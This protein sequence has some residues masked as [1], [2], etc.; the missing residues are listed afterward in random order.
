[1]KVGPRSVVLGVGA[2]Y[3]AWNGLVVY[4]LSRGFCIFSVLVLM[5]YFQQEKMLYI[6]QPDKK[7]PKASEFNPKM[8]RSPDEW[9]LPYESVKIPTSD[10]VLVHGWWIPQAGEEA[11]T[12]WTMLYFHGNAGN[13]GTRL[14]LVTQL[15]KQNRV[16]VLAVEYRGYGES[17]G[18][19][20][21]AGLCLDAQAALQ[22][23]HERPDIDHSKIIVFGRSLGGAV[24]ID[25]AYHNQ[26]TAKQT[27]IAGL[28]VENSFTCV[29]DVAGRALM[30]LRVLP[31]AFVRLLVTNKWLSRDKVGALPFPTLFISGLED[32]IIPPEQVAT[33]FALAGC[34][35]PATQGVLPACQ[36]SGM[37]ARLGA[38]GQPVLLRT[39]QAG[40]NDTPVRVGAEYT[41]A[42]TLFLEGI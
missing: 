2:F 40:H 17:E 9:G 42:L 19:P 28:I 3:L 39:F 10:G 34:K 4:A 21:E 30:P 41:R 20:S 26:S 25:L 33:L 12:A 24:A 1:M 6:P 29:A 23:L 31:R 16:N 22:H 18:T 7:I 15:Y 8:Y 36:A 11:K 32:Q 37:Q 5:L 13:I 27:K 14:P 35:G 38:A